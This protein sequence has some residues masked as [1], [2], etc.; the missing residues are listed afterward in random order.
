MVDNAKRYGFRPYAVRGAGPAV[1]PVE[2]IVAT[3]Q[4]F[5]VNGGAQSVNLRSGDPVRRLAAGG[6]NLADGA[7]GGGGAL[8]VLGIMAAVSERG[9]F[10]SS[11]GQ[12]GAM[13]PSKNL[14][15]GIAW[16]TL[17]ER[18]SRILMFDASAYTWACQVDDIVTAT[19]EAAYQALI[20]SNMDHRLQAPVGETSA[21]PQLDVSTT[22]TSSALIWRVVGLSLNRANEDFAEDNV[23]LLV[24]INVPQGAPYQ[25]TGV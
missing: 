23:E 24:N 10:D 3:G 2:V 22:G 11:I 15:S 8:S 16:G 7:E 5:D 18:Q 21:D 14:P 20:G 9:Y 4:D 6:I 1:G 17:I 12:N 13:R 25:G 19:T